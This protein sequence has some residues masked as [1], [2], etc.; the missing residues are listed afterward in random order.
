G[1][2]TGLNPLQMP[3]TPE[4]RQFLLEWLGLLAGG[5]RDGEAEQVQD[6]IEANF[7]QPVEQRRLRYLAELFRGYGRPGAGD[8]YSRLKPWWGG[9]DRA[10]LFDNE[11]DRTD[12]KVDVVGFDM[13]AVLD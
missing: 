2:P 8:L 4:N 13:T 9:G 5:L 12:L 11:R 10:W 3:D 1:E 6:A 7:A